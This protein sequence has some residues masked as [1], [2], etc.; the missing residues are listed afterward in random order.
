M[1]RAI[2]TCTNIVLFA[3]FQLLIC[4]NISFGSSVEEKLECSSDKTKCLKVVIDV[5][6]ENTE[7][8]IKKINNQFVKI[9][10]TKIRYPYFGD[11]KWYNN[12]ELLEINITTGSP[13]HYSIF[14]S[15]AKDQ[16]STIHDFPI[17][18]E[19]KNH[20]VLLGQEEVFVTKIFDP[21]YKFV[22]DEDFEN[23]AI[24]WLVVDQDVTRF[25]SNGDLVI[26][27]TTSK[28]NVVEKTIPSANIQLKQQP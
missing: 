21:T 5:D 8:Y 17:A 9:Y 19:P 12:N 23:S 25:T 14:Y 11:L 6:T 27:F 15:Y 10:E 18:V 2:A 28:N 13:G 4:K 16:V 3:L 26:K 22:I 20:L 7:Y 1:S 24:K